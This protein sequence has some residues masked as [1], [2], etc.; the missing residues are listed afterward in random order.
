MEK[1]DNRKP[2]KFLFD[3]FDGAVKKRDLFRG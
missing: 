1:T 3:F 2:Q